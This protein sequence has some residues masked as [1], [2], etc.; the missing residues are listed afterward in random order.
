MIMTLLFRALAEVC[1]C[2]CVCLYYYL[3]VDRVRGF[4]VIFHICVII[5]Y[6]SSFDSSRFMPYARI[7]LL[8]FPEV[9]SWCQTP[10]SEFSHLA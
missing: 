4:I 6:F 8:A 1:M 3:L 7:A 2:I 10:I 5:M 9:C